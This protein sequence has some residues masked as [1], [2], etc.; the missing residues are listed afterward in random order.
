MPDS[1]F[2]NLAL[3]FVAELIVQT[4]DSPDDD[5]YQRAWQAFVDKLI[6]WMSLDEPL[7]IDAPLFHSIALDTQINTLSVDFTQVGVKCFL[8]WCQ[9]QGLSLLKVAS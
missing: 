3:G 8:A 4:A 9:R 2:A 6:P 7:C 5:A 1:P